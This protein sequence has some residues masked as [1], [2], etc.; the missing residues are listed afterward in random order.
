[1]GK[2]SKSITVTTNEAVGT[3]MLTIKGEVIAK[4]TQQAVPATKPTILNK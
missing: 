1:V 3:K 2:F 4:E